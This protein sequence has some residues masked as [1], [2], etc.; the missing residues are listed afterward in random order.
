VRFS[1]SAASKPW[2]HIVQTHR[3][4]ARLHLTP[5]P[6]PR[7]LVLLGHGAGGDARA[8]AL[9]AVRDALT[10]AGAAVVLLDQPYVVAGRRAPDPAPRLD[11]VVSGVVEQLRAD[12][13][14]VPLVVGGKS[15]GARVGC[16]VAQ[17]VGAI[18]VL[19]LGF[20]LRPP[21]RPER[22]RAAELAAGCPVL[23]VQGSRDSFGTP[24]EVRSAAAGLPV[25]VHAVASGDHSFVPRKADGRTRQ[26]CLAEVATVA[27]RW[28][29]EL[30]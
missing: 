18:G 11:E 23:V 28:V 5:V 27:A 13:S 25:T 21:G 15:S 24:D 16:R 29:T 20:P 3:G 2:I 9:V 22:S 6:D 10:V 30:L 4:P 19:A 14:D 1:G 26:E 8:A 17:A 12:W 7:A